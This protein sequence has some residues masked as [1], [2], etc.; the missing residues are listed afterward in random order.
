MLCKKC[1]NEKEKR[2]RND[3]NYYDWYCN[4]CK[5]AWYQKN[6]KEQQ[7]KQRKRYYSDHERLIKAKKRREEKWFSG[8]R[9][10]CL[11]RDEYKCSTCGSKE[12]LCVH[13]KDGCGRGSKVLNNSLDNLI[14]LCSACHQKIH[15]SKAWLWTEETEKEFRKLQYLSNREIARRLGIT[16]PTVS[17]MRCIFT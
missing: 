2:W 6:K 16:H 12:R 11:K 7:Y 5:K 1:G 3:R 10:D 14:T 15:N 13:H 17:K 8:L 4:F 9:E